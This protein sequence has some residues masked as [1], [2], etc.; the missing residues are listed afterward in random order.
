MLLQFYALYF[1]FVIIYVTFKKIYKFF[2]ARKQFNSSKN[3]TNIEMKE[4]SE[5]KLDKVET[6]VNNS[7]T[8]NSENEQV[9]NSVSISIT[10]ENLSNDAENIESPVISKKSSAVKKK[11]NTSSKDKSTPVKSIHSF[12]SKI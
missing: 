1:R 8:S 3:V 6:E 4:E 10:Q 7:K 5:P 2:P 12:F 9:G 11:A